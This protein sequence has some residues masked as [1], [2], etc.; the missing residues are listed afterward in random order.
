MNHH[1]NGPQ[2]CPNCEDKLKL[3]HHD[4]ADW[5]RNTVR[6][7]FNDCHIAWS[8]RGK[9]DQE[10]CFL[11]GKTDLHFPLSPHNKSDDQGNP[12]SLAL[13][14][15]QQDFHGQGVWSW[16]YCRDIADKTL[17][18]PHKIEWAGHWQSIKGKKLGDFDHFQMHIESESGC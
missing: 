17:N 13:D 4:I 7:L 3:A 14:L 10:Q 12:C 2:P 9:E 16:G 11:N 15:F 6:P 8:F 5:F 18:G 1:V